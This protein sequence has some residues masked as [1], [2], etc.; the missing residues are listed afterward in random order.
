MTN[1]ITMS[2]RAN[3]AVNTLPKSV[4]KKVIYLVETLQELPDNFSN[5]HHKVHKLKN[6]DYFIA[7]VDD[8]YRMI[9]TQKNNHIEIFDVFHHDR[10]ELFRPVN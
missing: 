9:F 4:Q 6:S 10:L 3:I 2:R 5:Y 8:Q 1:Q 7:R